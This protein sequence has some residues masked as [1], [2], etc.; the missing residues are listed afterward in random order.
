MLGQGLLRYDAVL[1]ALSREEERAPVRFTADAFQK[2]PRVIFAYEPGD[3]DFELMKKLTEALKVSSDDILYLRSQS[4]SMKLPKKVSLI[5]KFGENVRLAEIEA[6]ATIQTVS[7]REL[8]SSAE[9]KKK[10]WADFKTWL[11][12]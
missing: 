1:R 3:E 9:M 10:L 8:Q 5:V 6:S 7:L 4:G 11:Q 12:S 2:N